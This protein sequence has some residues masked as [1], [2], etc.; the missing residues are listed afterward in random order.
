MGRA[1]ERVFGGMDKVIVDQGG[2]GQPVV[3]FLPLGS[4]LDK[5]HEGTRR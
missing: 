1:Q 3:P 5:P 2:D 4:L